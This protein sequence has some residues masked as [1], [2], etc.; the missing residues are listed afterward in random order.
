MD[1]ICTRLNLGCGRKKIAGA[2]NVDINPDLE[3]DLAHDLNRRPW[4]IPSDSFA[5]VLANDVIEHCEDVIATMEEI[6]RVACDGAI[7]RITV[8]HFSCV[9]A[10]A[11]PTHR[12]FFAAS[13]FGYF[14]GEHELSFYSRARFRLRVRSLIFVPTPVNRIVSRVANRWPDAYERRWA[15]LFPAW[16]LYF[17]L[18]AVKSA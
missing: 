6:H 4:P 14:T 2:L 12:H 5:E 8:P 7:V 1:S 13:S 11:D 16:F 10:F 17:E 18:E 9:N 3:P 15:W